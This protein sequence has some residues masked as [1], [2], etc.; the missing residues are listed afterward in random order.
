MVAVLNLNHPELIA[1][2]SDLI[3]HLDG[4]LNEG[5]SEYELMTD[6]LVVSS[7]GA[8]ASFANVAIRYLQSQSDRVTN[9][10]TR[11]PRT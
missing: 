8:R 9:S 1:D 3:E 10:A 6:F 11:G 4:E 7:I 2:R 5:V